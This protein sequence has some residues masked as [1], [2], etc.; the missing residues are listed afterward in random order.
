MPL[1]QLSESLKDL[2]FAARVQGCGGLIQNQQLRIAQ[3]G[4]RQRHPLPLS[5]G[6]IHAAFEASAELLVVLARKASDDF[7][8]K[9]HLRGRLDLVEAI[10]LF[11]SSDGNVVS[12]RHLVAH[13]ILENHSN[14]M[15]KIFHVVIPQVH[16]VDKDLPLGGVIQTCDEFYDGGFALTIFTDQSHA[17]P[18]AKVKIEILQHKPCGAGIGKRN[19]P[20]FDPLPNWT[21]DLNGVRFRFDGGLHGKE[22]QQI[23]QE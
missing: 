9:A 4:A 15:A 19:I 1:R 21:R 16:A 11:N 17:L 2:L 10:S 5:A 12:R 3:V 6:Q 13:E 18:G 14:F 23:R 7:V 22:S 20:E 8:R